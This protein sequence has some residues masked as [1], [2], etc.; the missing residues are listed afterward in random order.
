LARG[1]EGRKIM[2][3]YIAS[4]QGTV[5]GSLG[6]PHIFSGIEVEGTDEEDARINLYERYEHVMFLKLVEKKDGDDVC[7]R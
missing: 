4:F 5:V 3:K 6:F 7:S 1:I 2:T